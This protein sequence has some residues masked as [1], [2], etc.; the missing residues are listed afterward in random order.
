[1]KKNDDDFGNISISANLQLTVTGFGDK[2][3]IRTI[4][5]I[6]IGSKSPI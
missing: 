6:I 3:S 4:N 2:I 5:T 1:M